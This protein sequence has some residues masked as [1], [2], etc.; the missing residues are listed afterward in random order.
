MK[1]NLI[2]KFYQNLQTIFLFLHI[3][4][5][6]ILTSTLNDKRY[7]YKVFEF[8]YTLLIIK[9]IFGYTLLNEFSYHSSLF[10]SMN[11]F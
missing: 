1:L 6:L 5:I 2:T 9:M 11:I 8:D 10:P 4:Y 7:K 3:L